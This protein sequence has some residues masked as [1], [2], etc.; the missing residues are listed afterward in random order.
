VRMKKCSKLTAR[1]RINAK[2][3]IPYQDYYAPCSLN[4][5]T[6][7]DINLLTHIAATESVSGVVHRNER[8]GVS[9]RLGRNKLFPAIRGHFHEGNAGALGVRQ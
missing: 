7:D 2:R 1:R 4:A 5:R 6:L 9:S 3:P 8:L